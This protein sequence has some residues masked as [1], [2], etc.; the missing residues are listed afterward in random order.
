MSMVG[1]NMKEKY[2]TSRKKKLR[3][4]QGFIVNNVIYVIHSTS[5]KIRIFVHQTKQ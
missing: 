1:F 4:L 5:L 2:E 3:N